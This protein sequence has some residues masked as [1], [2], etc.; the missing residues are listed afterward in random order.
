MIS[1]WF[2]FAWSIFSPSFYFYLVYVEFLVDTWN[3]FLSNLSFNWYAFSVFLTSRTSQ[4][5][6]LWHWDRRPQ[7]GLSL[8]WE[9][10]WTNAKHILEWCQKSLPFFF[11][12]FFFFQFK[13]VTIVVGYL[14]VCSKLFQSCLTHYNSM[15]YSQPGSSVYGFFQG[16]TQEWIAKPFSREA[17]LLRNQTLVSNV[18]C[19]GRQVLYH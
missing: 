1:V 4:I 7:G 12:F 8:W 16:K 3:L 5:T 13:T 11:F 14:D 17:S 18:S 2:V 10:S 6:S 9:T 15:D 19:I